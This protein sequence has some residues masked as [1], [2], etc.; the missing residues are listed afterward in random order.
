MGD[1][2]IQDF[3]IDDFTHMHGFNHHPEADEIKVSISSPV[4]PP[5]LRIKQSTQ[6]FHIYNITWK[7]QSI[8]TPLNSP[9]LVL[10]TPVSNQ[11][12]CK[13]LSP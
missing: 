5:E 6:H 8:P 10:W 4:F 12:L 7:C 11:L 9:Q 3:F 2:N 1:E 13:C